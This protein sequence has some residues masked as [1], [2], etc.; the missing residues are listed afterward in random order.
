MFELVAPKMLKSLNIMVTFFGN[1]ILKAVIQN[2]L[3]LYLK[4]LNN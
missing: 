4:W 2:I 3:I 1:G